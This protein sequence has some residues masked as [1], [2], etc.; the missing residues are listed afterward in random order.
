MNV[1]I[2]ELGPPYAVTVSVIKMKEVGENSHLEM[3]PNEEKK[4]EEDLVGI[5]DWVSAPLT[6]IFFRCS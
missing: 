1:H 2:R 5:P 6:R 3:I 4:A